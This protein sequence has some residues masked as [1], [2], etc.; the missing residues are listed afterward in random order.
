M[1]REEVKSSETTVGSNFIKLFGG[2]VYTAVVSG[3]HSITTEGA[4]VNTGANAITMPAV[5][6]VGRTIVFVQVDAAVMTITQ[7]A[8]GAEI[9]GVDAS[10][11]A[12]DNALDTATFISDGTQWLL[13]SLNTTA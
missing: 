10:Y 12:L 11:T 6:T 4:V 13:T 5:A 1:A 2:E 9:N 8:D 7:N 3:D